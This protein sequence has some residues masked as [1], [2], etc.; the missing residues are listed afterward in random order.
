MNLTTLAHHLSLLELPPVIDQAL[1]TGRCTSP[2]TLHELIKLH[3]VEP[4]RVRALVDRQTEI[5]RHV[6]MEL[7]FKPPKPNRP[8]KARSMRE[9]PPVRR[10]ARWQAS[11]VRRAGSAAPRAWS[12]SV[13]AIHCNCAPCPQARAAPDAP[14]ACT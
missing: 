8:A 4:D 10:G 14:A 6:V 9:T 13:D 5:T 1:R 12:A 11:G 3:E 7:K 2:R